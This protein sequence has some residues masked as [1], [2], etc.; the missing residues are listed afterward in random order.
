[1]ARRGMREGVA[2]KCTV[3]GGWG[4]SNKGHNANGEGSEGARV[5]LHGACAGR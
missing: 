5:T 2:A 3:K 4:R 1:M